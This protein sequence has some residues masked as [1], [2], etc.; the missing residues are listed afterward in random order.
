M[1][2]RRRQGRNRH[3]PRRHQTAFTALRL[4]AMS[5]AAETL[6]ATSDTADAMALHIATM[7]ALAGKNDQ[8]LTWLERAVEARY[9]NSVYLGVTPE[10]D[11]LRDE[12][13]FIDLL[14]R[15]DLPQ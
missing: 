15:M 10:V 9:P 11:S 4:E 3:L 8:A 1:D 2:V 14:R 13:R 6:S 7:Y 12:P 5:V